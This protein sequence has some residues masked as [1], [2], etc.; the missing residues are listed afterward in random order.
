MNKDV[1][2]AAWEPETKLIDLAHFGA[3]MSNEQKKAAAAKNAKNLI[4][5]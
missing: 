5:L 2:A 1:D 4:L 3:S